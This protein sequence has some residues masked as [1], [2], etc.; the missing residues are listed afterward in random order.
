MTTYNL[1]TG[2]YTCKRLFSSSTSSTLSDV[3]DEF[4]ACIKF[5]TNVLSIEELEEIFSQKMSS[6]MKSVRFPSIEWFRYFTDNFQR[7][8]RTA[9]CFKASED[10]FTRFKNVA[11][12]SLQYTFFLDSKAKAYPFVMNTRMYSII[13]IRNDIP[14]RWRGRYN[15]DTILSLC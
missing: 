7:N 5:I 2:S 1:D 10:F 3:R 11:M 6:K 15:E 8:M 14:Y 4:V 9:V 12:G 13:F